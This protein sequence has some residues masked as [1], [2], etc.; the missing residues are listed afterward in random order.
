MT[1]RLS[2]DKDG[3]LNAIIM[4][5]IKTPAGTVISTAF[6]DCVQTGEPRVFEAK[7]IQ[8]CLWPLRA[9]E[10]CRVRDL[11]QG[12]RDQLYAEL[13]TTGGKHRSGGPSAVLK[14]LP[15]QSW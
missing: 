15:N 1:G 6:S 2:L 11:D 13:L 5:F 4:A 3:P 7:V 14:R 10:C 9:G 12:C 8:R